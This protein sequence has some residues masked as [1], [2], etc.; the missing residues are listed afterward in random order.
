MGRFDC[1]YFFSITGQ[2][3]IKCMEFSTEKSYLTSSDVLLSFVTAY[4]VSL[5]YIPWVEVML[6]LYITDSKK[7]C[8]CK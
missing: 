2:L 1:R 8:G 5:Y 3:D 7:G 4:S 6:F